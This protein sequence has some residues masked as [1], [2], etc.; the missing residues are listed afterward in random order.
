MIGNWHEPVT[1]G[2]LYTEFSLGFMHKGGK[3][4]SNTISKSMRP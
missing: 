2:S 4:L 1:L 3:A